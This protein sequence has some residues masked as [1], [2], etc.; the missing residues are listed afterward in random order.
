[1]PHSSRRIPR[2]EFPH[3][4]LPKSPRLERYRRQVSR[5]QEYWSNAMSR[6]TRKESK[7]PTHCDLCKQKLRTHYV[8]GKMKTNGGSWAY[9]CLS[10]FRREGVGIGTGRGTHFALVD[11]EWKRSTQA[12]PGPAFRGP[13]IDDII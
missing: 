1:M 8:D 3:A 4:K 11:G 10:C 6:S 2:P 9:M 12:I 7:M 5:R 13:T